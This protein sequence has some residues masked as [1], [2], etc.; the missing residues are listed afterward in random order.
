VSPLL[1]HS[2]NVQQTCEIASTGMDRTVWEIPA[3]QT[4]SWSTIF[5]LHIT[6][7]TIGILLLLTTAMGWSP[8][9]VI[10]VALPIAASPL[11][12]MYLSQLFKEKSR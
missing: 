3:P 8:V 4:I 9:L 11:L 6:E 12:A 5:G 2:L 10:A 7:V 1:A